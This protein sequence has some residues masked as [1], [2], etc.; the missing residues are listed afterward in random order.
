MLVT[1]AL[2]DGRTRLRVRTPASTEVRA[3]GSKDAEQLRDIAARYDQAV[4]TRRDTEL[5]EIG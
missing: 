3:F 4:V 2:E 5:L 1:L